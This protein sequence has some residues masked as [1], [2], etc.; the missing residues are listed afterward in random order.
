MD[1]G[2]ECGLSGLLMFLEYIEFSS[3]NKKKPTDIH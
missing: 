1:K 2:F 3:F